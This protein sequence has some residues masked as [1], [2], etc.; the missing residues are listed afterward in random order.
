MVIGHHP[1]GCAIPPALPNTE[2]IF[3]HHAFVLKVSSSW[4][5]FHPSISAWLSDS[6]L[7]QSLL[8]RA[9]PQFLGPEFICPVHLF[10]SASLTFFYPLTFSSCLGQC[11]RTDR[12]KAHGFKL[13]G[14]CVDQV[15]GQPPAF[16][17]WNHFINAPFSPTRERSLPKKSQTFLFLTSFPLGIK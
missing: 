1:N 17:T 3:H 9:P 16:S 5:N 15:L 8:Q 14:S 4:N 13:N 6:P 7:L 12:G 2:H 11:L 10:I